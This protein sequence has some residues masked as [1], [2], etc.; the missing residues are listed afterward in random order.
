MLN[1]KKLE[2]IDQVIKNSF[3]SSKI[4]FLFRKA[5]LQFEEVEHSKT[6]IQLTPDISTNQ[7][8][9]EHLELGVPSFQA[10]FPIPSSRQTDNN[11]GKQKFFFRRN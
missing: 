4:L 8:D 5:V 9:F 2:Q 11:R 10:H 7:D 3:H 1:K 6:S